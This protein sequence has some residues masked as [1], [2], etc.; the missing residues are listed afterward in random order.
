[1]RDIFFALT[2]YCCEIAG[3]QLS[4]SLRGS[5]PL[6]FSLLDEIVGSLG[7]G[8]FG[9]VVECVDHAR[10]ASFPPANS[11]VP[12]ATRSQAWQDERWQF[13]GAQDSAGPNGCHLPLVTV[14]EAISCSKGP[15]SYRGPPT[16]CIRGSRGPTWTWCCAACSG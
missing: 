5:R 8:T 3:P 14:V 11:A 16:L 1:V 13:C 9:K 4:P 15:G 6:L 12:R 7:E 2:F 10:W